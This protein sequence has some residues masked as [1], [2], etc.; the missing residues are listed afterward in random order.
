MQ[1]I[2]YVIKD[3]NGIHARPAGMLVK[4]ASAFKSNIKAIKNEKSADCKKLFGLMG[5]GVKQNDEIKI[6]ISGE[7]EQEAKSDIE[8]FLNENLWA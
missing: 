4:K 8:K 6:E 5:L 2:N 1:T 3:E 7:D